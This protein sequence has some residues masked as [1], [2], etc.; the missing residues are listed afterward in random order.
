MYIPRRRIGGLEEEVGL[1]A[2]LEA[3]FVRRAWFFLA[4]FLENIEKIPTGIDCGGKG[5]GVCSV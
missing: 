2:G 3:G 4:W 1:E 5:G